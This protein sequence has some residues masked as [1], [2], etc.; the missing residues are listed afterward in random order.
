MR[1]QTETPCVYTDAK[2]PLMHVHVRGLVVHVRVLWIMETPKQQSMHWKCQSLQKAEAGRNTEAGCNPTWLS[3]GPP[4]C[5]Y[6]LTRLDH[7]L[8][9]TWEMN[10]KFAII[11][12]PDTPPVFQDCYKSRASRD[13]NFQNDARCCV[14]QCK[15]FSPLEQSR[16]SE[17]G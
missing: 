15:L 17:H 1:L 9:Q 14:V 4:C 11:F 6:S 2:R 3:L 5:I 16:A 8:D 10:Q 13:V 7:H 12:A